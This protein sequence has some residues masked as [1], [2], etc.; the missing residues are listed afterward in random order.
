MPKKINK[1][2]LNKLKKRLPAGWKTIIA[3]EMK[4]RPDTVRK[5]L[6]GTR[7]N[8]TVLEKAISMCRLPEEEK[9]KLIESIAS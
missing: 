2:T 9:M 1:R 3:N 4:L 7:Y 8:S 6:D 5:I